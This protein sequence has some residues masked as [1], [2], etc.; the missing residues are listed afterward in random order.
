MK[1]LHATL[2][3]NVAIKVTVICNDACNV[4]EV[5]SISTFGSLQ[6]TLHATPAKPVT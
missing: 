4:A 3:A 6:E 1:R 2:R 5:G